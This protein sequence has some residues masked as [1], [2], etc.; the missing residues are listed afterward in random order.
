MIQ[1]GV[2]LL[3]LNALVSVRL[4]E[5]DIEYPSRIEDVEADTVTVA[6]P[7]GANAMLLASGTREVDLSWV[8]PRGR[9]EQRCQLVEHINGPVKRWR[10]RPID[11]ALLI[12]RRRYVRV[13]AAL[14]VLV[15]LPGDVV[16]ATTMDVSEGGFRVRMERRDI[17]DM[18]PATLHTTIGGTTLEI[19]GVVLRTS[20]TDLGQTEAVIA[21]EADGREGDAIR[22]FVFQLQLRARASRQP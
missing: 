4:A 5:Q 14:A 7:P 15:I 16:P 1:A 11:R 10:L 22:R 12:Q 3:S 6:A 17:E 9:Y 19:Q 20:V 13:R 2:D 8:S 18:T 21:F